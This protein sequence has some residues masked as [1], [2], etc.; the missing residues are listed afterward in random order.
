MRNLHLNFSITKL[1]LIINPG[2]PW[3]G[4]SPD[5]VVTCDCHGTGVLEIKCPFNANG[6]AFRD[7]VSD[8]RFCLT[9]TAEGMA[10]KPD[11]SYMYQLQ[12]QMCVAGVMYGDFIVWTPQELFMQRVQFD[13]C[14]FD[15]AYLRVEEFIKTGVLPELLGKWFTVPR[16]SS[17]NFET[18]PEGCYC[19]NPIDEADIL[20]CTSGQCKRKKFHKSCLKLSRVPKSWKCV[21][22]KKQTKRK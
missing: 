22:C 7:C 8:P 9:M 13:Q 14:F 1:G 12:T 15:E 17:A 19:G 11:H 21:E 10:L 2:L 4:A 3:V 18:A 5:G 20:S 16:L 6:R